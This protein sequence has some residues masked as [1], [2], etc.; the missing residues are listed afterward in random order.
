MKKFAAW[1]KLQD[2]VVVLLRLGEVDQLDDVGVIELPHDLNLFKNICS[3][4]NNENDKSVGMFTRTKPFSPPHACV[5]RD[6]EEC[7]ARIEACAFKSE[8]P[9]KEKLKWSHLCSLGSLW[10]EVRMEMFVLD[11]LV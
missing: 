3:L 7:H 8:T 9:R 4:D 2:D 5:R 10:L 11:E 6:G 1:G